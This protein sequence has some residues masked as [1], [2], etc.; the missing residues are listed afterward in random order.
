[1]GFVEVVNL[2]S[3]FGTEPQNSQLMLADE[4]FFARDPRG[5]W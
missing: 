4:D 1:M 3:H 2:E 5:L